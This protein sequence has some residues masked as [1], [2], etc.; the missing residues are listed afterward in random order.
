MAGLDG[1]LGNKPAGMKRLRRLSR[2]E[3]LSDDN[4]E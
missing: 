1:E 3:S 4:C 2:V